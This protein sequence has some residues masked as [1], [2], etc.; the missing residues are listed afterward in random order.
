MNTPGIAILGC[1]NAGN[2]IVSCIHRSGIIGAETIAVNTDMEHLKAARAD[3]RILIG[4]ALKGG[5][6]AGGCPVMGRHAAERG[7]PT[8]SAVME[9]ADLVFIT[10]GLGGGTGSGSLPLIAQVARENGALVICF[11]TIPSGDEQYPFL[12]AQK[13]LRE[14]LDYADSVII[15]DYRKTASQYP[16]LSP[17]DVCRKMDRI[18]ADTLREI[19][20]LMTVPSLVNIDFAD[21]RVIFRN[22]GIATILSGESEDGVR[23]K[24]ESVFQSMLE[25]TSAGFDLT[26]ASGCLVCITGGSDMNRFYADDIATAVSSRLD[27]HADIVWG[28]NV[29]ED[30]DGKVRV[31]AIVTGV[32]GG[33][34]ELLAESPRDGERLAGCGHEYLK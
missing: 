33:A 32:L 5:L 19:T 16:H 18:I 29:T 28:L 12:H 17:V 1:G 34:E 20:H 3:K 14:T 27:P 21:F 7:I 4:K 24:N 6:G 25:H 26:G 8:I 22:R 10:A 31:C 2:D 15:A 30:V 23:N 11:V 9:S 13:S